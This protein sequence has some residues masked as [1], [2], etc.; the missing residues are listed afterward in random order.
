MKVLAVI[1]ISPICRIEFHLKDRY[2][3]SDLLAG[4]YWYRVECIKRG[5]LGR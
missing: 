5:G 4:A 1:F 3:E 2:N